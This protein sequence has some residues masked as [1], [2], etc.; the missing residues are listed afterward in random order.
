M[1]RRSQSWNEGLAKDLKDPHFASGFIMASLKEE[2]ISPQCVL[3]KVVLSYG[4][5]EFSK[6][7][8]MS[9][10]NISRALNQK[11]NPTIETLNRLLKPFGLRLVVAPIEKAA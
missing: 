10:S 3:R 5:K 9:S 11:Y 8:K 6:K 4:L 2:G 7:V 1:S